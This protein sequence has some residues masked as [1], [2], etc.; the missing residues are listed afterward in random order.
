[1]KQFALQQSSMITIFRAV[2]E[3]ASPTIIKGM[4]R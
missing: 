3:S 1:M 4:R 2:R